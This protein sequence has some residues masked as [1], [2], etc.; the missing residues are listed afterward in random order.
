MDC[1]EAHHGSLLLTDLL[2]GMVW[3]TLVLEHA[4]DPSLGAASLPQGTCTVTSGLTVSGNMPAAAVRSASKQKPG[5]KARGASCSTTGQ[6][7]RLVSRICRAALPS[8]SSLA[9]I[10]ILPTA[11]YQPQVNTGADWSTPQGTQELHQSPLHHLHS[12]P[13]RA[14]YSHVSRGTLQQPWPCSALIS[15]S[16]PP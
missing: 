5:W 10:W 14:R 6:A 13:Y 16:C 11:S 3:T 9:D 1:A 4:S 8:A 2:S 15:D 7:S 12:F